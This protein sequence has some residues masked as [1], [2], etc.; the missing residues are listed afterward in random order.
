MG[1]LYS[2]LAKGTKRF[3]NYLK[4]TNM[5]QHMLQYIKCKK[6]ILFVLKLTNNL[7]NIYNLCRNCFC[8]FRRLETLQNHQQ[9]CFNNQTVQIEMPNY[10]LKFINHCF[11]SQIPFRIYADFECL[12]E[13]FN[14]CSLNPS[15]SFTEKITHQKP[16][17]IGIYIKSDYENI[18]KSEYISY[19]GNNVVE[20]FINKIVELNKKFRSKFK[21]NYPYDINS[22]PTNTNCYY[23]GTSFLDRRS[24]GQILDETKVIDH[25]HY[26]GEIRGYSC[27]KCNLKEGQITKFVP[28]YFHNLSNYDAHLFIKELAKEQNQYNK[29]RIL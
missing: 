7:N 15:N 26:N 10:N 13:K 9:L 4:S 20:L 27:S 14:S 19:T 16:I 1:Y 17:S 29:L 23:C 2:A 6:K 28:I 8:S 25:N 18:I 22:K 24:C 21:I 5:L 12:N 11:K 3:T